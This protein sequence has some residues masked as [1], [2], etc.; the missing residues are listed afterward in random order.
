VLQYRIK[1]LQS[2]NGVVQP[3]ESIKLKKEIEIL[4]YGIDGL[5]K[6]ERI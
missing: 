5:K 1:E 3:D 6:K 2:Q 4:N